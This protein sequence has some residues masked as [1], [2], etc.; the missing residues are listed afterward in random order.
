MG[1]K[2]YQFDSIQELQAYKK[3]LKTQW[4]IDNSDRLFIYNRKKTLERCLER[5]SV[6]TV[7]TIIRY[8]FSKEEL[9]PIFDATLNRV[10]Y[11]AENQSDKSDNSDSE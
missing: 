9:Q 5:A 11:L 4:D 10:M 8:K 6:P 1:R 7:K 3:Q 2:P